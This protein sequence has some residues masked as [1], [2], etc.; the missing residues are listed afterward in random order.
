MIRVMLMA[1]ALAA[2][3]PAQEAKQETA[4]VSNQAVPAPTPSDVAVRI[5]AA[6]AGQTVEVGVN[7]RFAIELV[8]VPTAGYV[9]APAQMPAFVTTAGEASGNTTQAQS[10]PGFVG[11]NHWEV[12]MFVANAPGT[13]EIVME[14][15]RPWE[16]DEPANNVFRVTIVAR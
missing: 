15:R 14:Q 12:S 5:T 9:W 7:Q 4:P 8:G 16:T 13:G 10:Q 3:T 1:A 2:C 6:Q 11:G